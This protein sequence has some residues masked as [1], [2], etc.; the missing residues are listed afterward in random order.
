MADGA[1]DD[2]H[3]NNFRQLAAMWTEMADKTDGRTGGTT[4]EFSERETID[5]A[6]ATIRNA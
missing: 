1:A 4:E 6:I 3:R 2:F 5:D